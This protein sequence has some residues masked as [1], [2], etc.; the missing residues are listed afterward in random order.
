MEKRQFKDKDPKEMKEETLELLN[1]LLELT[2]DHLNEKDIF[3][4][5][6]ALIMY[7]ALLS[8]YN[9]DYNITKDIFFLI[10]ESTYKIASIADE[11]KKNSN[12]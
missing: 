9:K 7:A 6:S 5:I 1:E 12:T 8:M 4:G 3:V 2:S 10:A 11:M